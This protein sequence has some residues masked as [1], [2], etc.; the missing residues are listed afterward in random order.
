M[1]DVLEVVEPGLLTT[2][3]DAGRTDL[4]HLGVPRS[5]ACDDRALAVANLLLGNEPTAAVLELTLAGVVLRALRP[6]V[7]GI[8]GADLGGRVTSTGRRVAPG[9][10]HRLASGDTVAFQGAEPEAHGARGAPGAGSAPGARAYVAVPGGIAVPVVLGSRST[11]LAA[12][13]GGLDGRPLRAG[14][15]LA[16]LRDPDDA[17]DGVTWP[18]APTAGPI[19]VLPGPDPEHLD[20]LLATDWSVSQTSDRVGLRLEGDAL[21]VAGDGQRRSHGVVPGTVQLPPDGRPIVL[22]ADAPPTGGYPVPAVAVTADLWRLGQLS[23]GAPV[24][25]RLVTPGEAR[26]GRDAWR[27]ELA[28]GIAHLARDGAWDE[29]WRSARG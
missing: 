21:D 5:G 18:G 13:F 6:C 12:G 20:R 19:R 17:P 10:S 4:G 3:Q 1:T 2:V 11:C 26:H 29:L 9:R 15:R 16:S 24:R 22:L 28:A 7:I 14:D 23:P 27:D 25:F 8:A